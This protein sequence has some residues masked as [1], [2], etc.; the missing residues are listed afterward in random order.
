MIELNIRRALASEAATLTEIARV[1][2][3]HWGYPDEWMALWEESLTVTASYVVSHDVFVGEVGEE[4]VGFYAL[5]QMETCWELD[6][7]WIR[8]EFMGRGFGRRLFNHAI[9][10]LKS[11]PSGAAL[12]IESDPN[13]ELFYVRMG[14]KRVGEITRDWNG[15]QR[16][17]PFLQFTLPVTGRRDR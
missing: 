10:Q 14:A 4:I 12:Q 17:T 13:A 11:G 9:E 2:K 6:H 7:L 8:P 3:H 1:A 15:L 5:V 16:T